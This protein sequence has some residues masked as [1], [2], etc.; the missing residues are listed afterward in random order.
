M[1]LGFLAFGWRG[2]LVDQQIS[3]VQRGTF[4]VFIFGRAEADVQNVFP[5]LEFGVENQ[6]PR[7]IQPAAPLGEAVAGFPF[8]AIDAI[9]DNSRIGAAGYE[10]SNAPAGEFQ[11]KT[12]ASLGRRKKRH[13]NE[14]AA[15]APADGR[16]PLRHDFE[17]LEFRRQP[18]TRCQ[19][20]SSLD[21]S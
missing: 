19:H 2:L 3:N 7:D 12:A 16:F 9:F 10:K 17:A 1:F 14:P 15:M 11:R 8:P 21:F 4:G 5:G 13:A 20:G 18:R 6:R